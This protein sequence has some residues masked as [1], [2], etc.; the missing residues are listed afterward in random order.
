MLREI[1]K[2]NLLDICLCRKQPVSVYAI[3]KI[4]LN[5]EGD[6]AKTTKTNSEA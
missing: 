3:V 6:K 4:A 2:A 5:Q 1:K